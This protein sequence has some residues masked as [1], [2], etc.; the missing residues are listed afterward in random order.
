VTTPAD[1]LLR[2]AAGRLTVERTV[3]FSLSCTLAEVEAMVREIQPGAET[4]ERGNTAEL[5]EL[6]EM[7]QALDDADYAP[8]LAGL[9]EALSEAERAVRVW[10]EQ[11]EALR[12]DG[13]TLR[14]EVAALTPG[15]WLDPAVNPPPIGEPILTIGDA[16][17]MA[18]GPLSTL[19]GLHLW[20]HRW[21]RIPSALL[22]PPEVTP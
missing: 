19:D 12:A 1:I 17:T 14:A 8:T 10:K 11:D 7:R 3:A 22:T 5:Q 2:I 20:L 6:A 9:R 4:I 21:R 16:G 15:P 18:L 13:D